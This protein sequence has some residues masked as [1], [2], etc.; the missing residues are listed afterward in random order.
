MEQALEV[1]KQYF[2]AGGVGLKM[3]YINRSEDLKS[4]KQAL[5]LYT[6]TTDDLIK[7]FV[8]TQ[9]NQGRKRTSKVKF[10]S[11][12]IFDMAPF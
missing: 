7:N 5:S 2:H 11:K 10:H 6:Q 3:S 9:I 4:L 8:S 1:F 12:Y